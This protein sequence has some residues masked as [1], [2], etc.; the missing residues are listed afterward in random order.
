MFE[1]TGHRDKI[2]FGSVVARV[3]LLRVQGSEHG[4]GRKTTLR[5][6]EKEKKKIDSLLAGIKNGLQLTLEGAKFVEENN[7]NI[8]ETSKAGRKRKIEPNKKGK[9]AAKK[10][11]NVASLVAR[12]F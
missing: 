12:H 10:E 8:G 7:E 4:R 3:T 5:L 6:P 1:K 11:K 2:S 9:N